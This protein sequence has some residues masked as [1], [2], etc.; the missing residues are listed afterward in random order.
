MHDSA[1]LTN[2][3]RQRVVSPHLQNARRRWAIAF[4]TAQVLAT[5]V[6]VAACAIE[7][8]SILVTGPALAVVGLMLAIAARPL[9]S[10]SMLLYSL[11][12][13]LVS[14][15]CATLIAALR[16]GPGEAEGP[17]LGIF[18]I[19]AFLSI[20]TALMVFPEIRQWSTSPQ[21]WLH[22]P[23]RYS[24]KS[25][26]LVTTALC[27]AVPALRFLFGNVRRNDTIIF[28]LFVLVTMS[29]VGFLLFVFVAGRRVR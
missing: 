18:F 5:V 23:W 29:L 28:S 9:R 1:G 24:L 7:I 26:L 12:G 19:Y 13:P 10:W 3:T 14:A 27:V 16:W 15:F 21:S 22:W 20:P 4:W 2:F 25:L 8:E 6:A 11:S 17:I